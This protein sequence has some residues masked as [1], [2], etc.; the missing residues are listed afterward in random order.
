VRCQFRDNASGHLLNMNG[1]GQ[2]VQQCVFGPGGPHIFEPVTGHDFGGEF[3]ECL[4][5]DLRPGPNVIGIARDCAEPFVVRNCIFEDIRVT[6]GQ[7]GAGIGFGCSENA[8]GTQ[9]IID[10]NIFVNCTGFVVRKCISIGPSGGILNRNRFQ[11]VF[12]A[13]IATVQCQGNC[14]LRNN[15]FFNTGY[16]LEAVSADARWNWWGDS[17]GPYHAELNPNGQGDEITG[18]V[19]FI[20]WYTDTMFTQDAVDARPELPQGYSLMAYPNPFNATTRLKLIV[21]EATI[22]SLDLFDILGRRVR[23]LWSGP[24]LGEH[25]I[26]FTADDLPSGIYFA[27]AMDVLYNRPLAKTK[28]V[29]LR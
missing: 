22:I 2:L 15:L 3:I 16:A 29:L 17:T 4:F 21:G 7:G 11:D 1:N 5:T 26:S 12:P 19:D 10:S 9:A 24:V 13:S 27:R 20:P 23:Q 6:S 14:V 18:N 28:L 8:P 25:E